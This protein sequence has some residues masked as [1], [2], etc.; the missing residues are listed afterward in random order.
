MSHTD[1]AA[2]I[3]EIQLVNN[4]PQQMLKVIVPRGTTLAET[5]RLQPNLSDIL[6][7]LKGCLPCN[8]GV[9]IWF[10][11]KEELEHVVKVDLATMKQVI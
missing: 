10:Q 11:E 8:S 6:G 1:K 2:K 4:G 9:P 7:K 5:I 3:A